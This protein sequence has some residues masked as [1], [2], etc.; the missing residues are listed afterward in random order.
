MK[1]MK[2]IQEI[3]LVQII[4][5]DVTMHSRSAV[6]PLTTSITMGPLTEDDVTG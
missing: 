6:C 5:A 1:I 2:S 4:F 3:T